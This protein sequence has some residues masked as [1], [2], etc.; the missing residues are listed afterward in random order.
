[1]TAQL[2]DKLYEALSGDMTPKFLATKDEAGTPNVVPIISIQPYDNETLIFG[3]FLMWKTEQ[4]LAVNPQVSVTV[5]TEGMYGAVIR[6][7]FLGFHKV[8]EYV[9]SKMRD[10]EEAGRKRS[11]AET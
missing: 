11:E 7:T 1:M 5:F 3:N 8:G 4:N 10:D 2:D 9:D 6:G